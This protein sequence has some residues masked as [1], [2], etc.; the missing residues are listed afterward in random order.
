MTKQRMICCPGE[1]LDRPDDAIDRAYFRGFLLNNEIEWGEALLVLGGGVTIPVRDAPGRDWI[2]KNPGMREPSQI[3]AACFDPTIYT[4]EFATQQDAGRAADLVDTMGE[5]LAAVDL[6][7][8]EYLTVTHM[9]EV[10]PPVAR[11]WP[12]T[13]TESA[14]DA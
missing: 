7:P 13:A 11:R 12:A 4:F 5:R 14:R 8:H 10:F 6:G 2:T 9:P 1:L 3:P